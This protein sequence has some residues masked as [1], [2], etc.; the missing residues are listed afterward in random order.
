MEEAG[1]DQ[2]YGYTSVKA[3]DTNKAMERGNTNKALDTYKPVSGSF[4]ATANREAVFCVER[5]TANTVRYA[6]HTPAT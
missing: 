3:E 6:R 2:L 1:L 5:Y 4:R